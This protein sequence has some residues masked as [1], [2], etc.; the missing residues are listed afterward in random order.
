MDSQKGAHRMETLEAIRTRRSIRRFTGEA[1]PRE[2]L[3]AL[4]DA[5]HWAATGS[6]KQPWEFIVITDRATIAQLCAASAWMERAAAVIAVVMDPVSRWWVEDGSAA[7]QNLLLAAHALGYGACWLEGYTIPHEDAFKALLSVP[8]ER[9]LFTLVPV[10]VP[11]EQP[12]R[13][14]KPLEQV[15]YW[16]KYGA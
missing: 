15:L 11:A 7:V 14:K 16:E 3:I 4:V 6:N 10:G 1:I 13:E 8:A 2:H 5:A 12:T 9:R